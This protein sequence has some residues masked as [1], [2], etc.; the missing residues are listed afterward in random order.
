[1]EETRSLSKNLVKSYYLTRESSDVKIIDTNELVAKKLERIKL[2]M[3]EVSFGSSEF[4]QVD[5][6]ENA[7]IA[8]PLDALSADFSDIGFE[9]AGL[10]GLVSERVE[11]EPVYTGPTPEELVA[12]AQ[13][14]IDEM[15]ASAARELEAERQRVLDAARAEGYAAGE[16]EAMRQISVM[17][18][19]VEEQKRSLRAAYEEQIDTLEPRFVSVL[20]NI[21]EKVFELDLSDKKSLV[22]GMLRNTM[23][24]L[25]GSKNYLVH[26]S[27][28]EYAYVK[29]HRSELLT[30]SA[31]GDTVVDIVEDS[32][33]KSG[34]CTIET[35]NGIYDCGLGTQLSEI[36]KKLMLLAYEG[37]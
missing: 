8:D 23:K 34:E 24:K 7:P 29:E 25:D 11:Q 28:E 20:T 36:K 13:A 35:V 27:S 9:E 4:E 16:Q 33:M 15:R 5:M 17:Q 12:Q 1:M 30:D 37:E 32:M 18:H 26:V 3:P 14:E 19:E 31:T 2:V 21:Y 22:V 10:S 6:F